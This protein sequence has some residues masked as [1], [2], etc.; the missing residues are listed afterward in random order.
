MPSTQILEP[1]VLEPSALEPSVVE[2]SPAPVELS[3]DAL[4][5]ATP[6]TRDRYVD[7]LRA[8]SILVV[9]LWHWVFSITQ[10]NEDGSLGMPNP[11]GEVPGLWL[12]TWVLQIMP[13]FFFVG[14]YANLASYTA[15]ER[16]QGGWMAFVQ[17][18]LRR[19]LKPVGIYVG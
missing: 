12:L 19:L 14:G 17:N 16:K 4:V 7:F 3:V 5:D 10:W 2:A 13:V 8:L 11:V 15:V 1:S 6:D 9:V 18:R